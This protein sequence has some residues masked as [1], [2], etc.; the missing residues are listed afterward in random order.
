MKLSAGKLSF[1]FLVFYSITQLTKLT[2]W[3]H[4]PQIQPTGSAIY[5]LGGKAQLHQISYEVKLHSYLF[6]QL[7]YVAIITIMADLGCVTY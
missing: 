5:H 1:F 7:S 3:L 6:S 4:D 2:P